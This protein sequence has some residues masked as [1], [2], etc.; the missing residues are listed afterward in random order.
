MLTLDNQQ[1]QPKTALTP[2]PDTHRP[3]QPEPATPCRAGKRPAGVGAPGPD[4]VAR[5]L[6]VEIDQ[7][8]GGQE[9]LLS[10]EARVAAADVELRPQMDYRRVP[11]HT[12]DPHDRR[13]RDRAQ[14][15]GTFVL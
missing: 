7:R 2:R 11:R 15:V 4:L 6:W 10:R 1:P 9:K 12:I 5:L 8:P 14:P 3:T 13:P